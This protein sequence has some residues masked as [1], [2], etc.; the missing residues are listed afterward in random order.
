MSEDA[1]SA[2]EQEGP[3]ALV[4]EVNSR[5]G[6]DLAMVGVADHG[7]SGGAVYVRWPEGRD[8]VVTRSP[9]PLEQAHRTAEVLAM[10]RS[11]GL[12]VP[13]HDLIV[14][15]SD[16]TVAN[17]QERLPGKPARRVD[18]S[19][20]DA[21]LAMN[22]RFAGL[23]VDRH[24]VP[25]PPMYLR[26]SGP[27]FPRHETLKGYDDRTRR[28]L[29]L[30]RDVGRS[31]QPEMVGDD[32]VHT[33]YTVPNVLFDDAGQITGVID[34]NFGVARGDR[35]FALV[36]LRFDLTWAA[37]SPGGDRVKQEAIDRVDE[38]LDASL[39]PSVLRMYWA[40]WTL[41]QLHWAILG[42]TREVIDLHIRLGEIRL[43]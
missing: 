6:C 9:G 23:L 39:E 35:R 20:I 11:R 8:G 30:I 33:D 4:A 41:Y 17:V 26:R 31:E 13:R 37:A 14:E 25:V 42:H 19:V 16:G 1:I 34:W 2:G 29:K 38:A 18:V 28:L 5:A 10:A 40:H 12:P 27:V 36:K 15:L 24:D 22:E 3:H 21:M 32:L 43:G 7:E